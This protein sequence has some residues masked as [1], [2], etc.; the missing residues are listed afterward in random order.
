[1]I[2]VQALIMIREHAFLVS[3]VEPRVSRVAYAVAATVSL[4]PFGYRALMLARAGSP[5]SIETLMTVAAIGAIAIGAAEEAAVV[6]FLFS[7]GELLE[8]VAAGR[9]RAGIK[10][11]MNLVPRVALVEEEGEG[12][13]GTRR[14]PRRRQCG[15]GSP[16]RPGALGR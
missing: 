5:F 6:V 13:R 8:N 14:P 12:A 15:R 11:L 1:M 16:G 7:V 9:A 10:A 4:F 3:W 2:G